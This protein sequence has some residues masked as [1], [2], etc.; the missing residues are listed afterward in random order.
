MMA[1]VLVNRQS[2]ISALDSE[3][4]AGR[5]G[6]IVVYGR[7]RV[8]KTFLVTSWTRLRR[9]DSIYLIINHSDELAATRDLERQLEAYLGFKPRLEGLRGF[10]DLISKLF[11]SGRRVVV[12]DEF[13]RLAEA[14]LPQLLQEAWDSRLS[15]CGSPSLL[16]LVGS[17]VGVVEKV[18]LSGGSPLYGRATRVIHMKP[19]TFTQA[20][21]L[22]AGAPNPTEAF[23]LYAVFGGIPLYLQLLRPEEGLLWNLRELVLSPGAPLLEEPLRVLEYE[24]REPS[25]YAAILEAIASGATRLSEIASYTGL[26]ITSIPK[27]LKVLEALDL[28]GRVKILPSGRSLY[29]VEDNF[30]RFWYRHIAPRLH[31]VEEGLYDSLLRYVREK[32][33]GTVAI[34][35]EEE[36][37][38]HF[39]SSLQARGEVIVDA[40]RFIHKGVEVDLVV[41]TEERVYGLECKWAKLDPKEVESVARKTLKALEAGKWTKQGYKVI[42]VLYV[43]EAWRAPTEGELYTLDDIIDDAKKTPVHSLND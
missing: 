21:P 4:H 38:K 17:S 12:L 22:V 39:L 13:Q 20:Y 19:L 16:V 36:A 1:T 8:G 26:R 2:E 5:P 31:L 9:I 15:K 41:V 11:C 25:R 18:A 30:A 40:G 28:V 37:A 24:V 23:R 33:E 6:L 3:W 42:P 32:V 7:R 27:Y 29:V 10:V 35:W 43:R 14:G 34:A